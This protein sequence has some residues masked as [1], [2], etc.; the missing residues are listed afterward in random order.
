MSFCSQLLHW[1][2][3]HG[4]TLPWRGINDPYRI[5][6]S[7]IILQQ[8]RIE[9]GTGYYARF[10]ERF[11]TVE[12]LAAAPL[13]EVL[14][15]W[16]GLGYYSRARNLHAAAQQIVER[17]GGV[18]PS[19]YE[20]IR[21]LKGVG[22]Y[23]AAAIASLAFKLPYPVI[24]GNV[25]RVVARYFDID[26][27]IGTD[28]AYSL[29]EQR[30]Q[31]LMDKGQPDRFNQAMMDFGA[32]QCKP[33]NPRCE[34]CVFALS[35][36]ALRRGKVGML[37][38]KAKAAATRHRYFYYADALCEGK[39]LMQQRGAG[40]I[41][42]GLFELPLVESDR[43]L[44]VAERD[45]RLAALLAPYGEAD[46]EGAVTRME[47]V[48]KLTHQTLHATFVQVKLCNPHPAPEGAARLWEPEAV[49]KL[50]VSRLIDKYLSRV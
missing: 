25:Y 11:P 34:D 46:M 9:Q 47:A 20:A 2:D 50:P 27:P 18:F 39:R 7:E 32:L 4:R 49:K 16:Q 19:D 38:V 43:P 40:D 23:T 44:T 33:A 21:A 31:G 6:L 24:D 3:E 42:Q 28:H 17:H 35:C 48:H 8:T 14:K 22:R 1:Y 30:L 45:E 37:P 36:A 10:V 13:E 29:F 26:T 41:W 12:A 5:W 15:C